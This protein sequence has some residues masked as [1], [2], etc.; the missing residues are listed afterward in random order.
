[1]DVTYNGVTASSRGAIVLSVSPPV[2]AARRI[3]AIEVP[4]RDGT[5]HIDDG[6]LGSVTKTVTLGMKGLTALDDIQAWLTGSGVL[7]STTEPDVAYHVHQAE[8]LD[9]ERIGRILYQVVA[10]F[11]CEPY[12]Y[13]YPAATDIT[14]TAPGTVTNPATAKAAPLLVIEGTGDITLTIG[15]QVVALTDLDTGITLDCAALV[16]HDEAMAN[17][18]AHMQG[19]YPVLLPGTNAI[20]WTGAVDSLTIT[21]RWRYL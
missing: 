15:N 9:W 10:V 13:A 16:A 14:L 18:S 12:R 2:R 8:A 3:S 5:L 4:G 7:T 21:P 17:M 11:D 20:S 1:M 19:D 6:S